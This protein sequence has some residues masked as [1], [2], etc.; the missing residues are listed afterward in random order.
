MSLRDI[1]QSAYLAEAMLIVLIISLR[2]SDAYMR[3]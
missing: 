1:E 3:R 2:P